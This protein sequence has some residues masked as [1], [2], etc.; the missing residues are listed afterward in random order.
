VYSTKMYSAQ[1]SLKTS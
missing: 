1:N